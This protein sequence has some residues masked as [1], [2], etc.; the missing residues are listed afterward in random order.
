MAEEWPKSGDCRRVARLHQ[1]RRDRGSPSSP[2]RRRQHIQHG[3]GNLSECTP[4]PDQAR[5]TGLR[6]Q[7]DCRHVHLASKIKSN[8]ALVHCE[9]PDVFK[10]HVMHPSLLKI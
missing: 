2:L 6:V 9:G 4:F 8:A 10:V 3:P 1:F 7:S 5:G